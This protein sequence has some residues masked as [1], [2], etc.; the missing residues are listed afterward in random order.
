[1]AVNPAVVVPLGQRG[2]F[3]QRRHGKIRDL[4]AAFADK[5]VV[6]GDSCVKVVGPVPEIQLLYL[7]DFREKVKVPVDGSQADIGKRFP[8][9]G[10][11][12]IG[13]RV[14]AALGQAAFDG[15]PLSAVF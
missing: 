12:H 14:I 13:C 4:M 11:Q 5:M 6:R 2:N 3:M 15:F 7:S 10:V 8:H 1:M 9:T